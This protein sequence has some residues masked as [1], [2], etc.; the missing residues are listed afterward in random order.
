M[1]QQDYWNVDGKENSLSAGYH[2]HI[3]R[4]NY[5]VAYTDEKSGMGRRRSL[6]VIQCFHPSGGRVEQLSH[7]YRPEWQDVATGLC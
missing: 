1:T 5:S 6:V 4:V 7:D 3:G 2:G